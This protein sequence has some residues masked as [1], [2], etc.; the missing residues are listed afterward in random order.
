MNKGS[1][2]KWYLAIG[3]FFCLVVGANA[4]TVDLQINNPPSNNVLDGIYVGSYSANNLSS[5][6]SVQ[7]TCDD[8]SDQSNYNP[9]TYTTNTFNSLGNTLWGSYMLASG[10]SMTQ[11]TQFY[12]E[13]AWLTEA[14]LKQT[15]VEQGYYSYAIWAVF[16]PMQVAGWLTMYG[17]S[18]ACNTVFGNGAWWW[19][20][21]NAGNGGLEGT[22][23]AQLFTAG[24]FANV[25]ILT[26]QGCYWGP[27]TCPE[28]EFLEVL[29]AEGGTTGLYLLMAGIACFAA[30]MFRS[31]RGVYEA[32]VA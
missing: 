28:Q 17:D 25:E 32:K 4:Q 2:M 7:I 18:T 27:G 24:E 12:D 6:G 15:G 11:V 16:D 14:M 8:F 30:I 21:C 29:V 1:F 26:P 10:Y 31:R 23:S 19:G 5:G 13:A 9:A 3:A 22:A 20:R